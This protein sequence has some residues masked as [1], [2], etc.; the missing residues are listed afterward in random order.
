MH[1]HTETKKRRPAT[2]HT[3]S[4]ILFFESTAS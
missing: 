1:L 2:A 4:L 3:I